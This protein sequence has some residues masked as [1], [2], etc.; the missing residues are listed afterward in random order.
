MARRLPGRSSGEHTTCTTSRS[1]RCSGTYECLFIAAFGQHETGQTAVETPPPPLAIGVCAH[2]RAGKGHDRGDGVATGPMGGGGGP[3]GFS[4]MAS[5][6]RRSPAASGRGRQRG[7]EHAE[8]LVVN[9]AF[10]E[11]RRE[12]D[13]RPYTP[14][15]RS[16][17]KNAAEPT[18]LRGFRPVVG[19]WASDKTHVTS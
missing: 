13:R 10:N 1:R 15:L 6:Q 12:R 11:P 14:R 18:R 4:V 7:L 17:W 9:G 5:A 16:V 8:G 3:G 19:T 2:R